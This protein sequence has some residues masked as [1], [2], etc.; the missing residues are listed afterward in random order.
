MK[1]V[2]NFPV[3]VECDVDSFSSE[4]ESIVA[5]DKTDFF[6]LKNIVIAENLLVPA[7]CISKIG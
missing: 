7:S 1:I 4:D 3:V 2:I 5:V 6:L